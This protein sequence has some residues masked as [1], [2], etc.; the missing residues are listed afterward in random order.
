VAWKL[1]PETVVRAGWGLFYDVAF[2]IATDPIN[3]LPYNR[4]QFSSSAGFGA[5]PVVIPPTVASY[6]PGL[7]LPYAGEWN[8]SIEHL[9]PRAGTLAASYVGS[10]GVAGLRREG[11]SNAG[12]RLVN[13]LVSTN[14]GFSHFHALEM[15]YH[16]ALAS[17]LSAT[18]AYTY[19]HSIDNGSWDN[20]VYYTQEPWTAASDRAS[21]SY[22]VRHNFTASLVWQKKNWRVAAIARARSGFPID[23]L[24]AENLLGLSFDDATR[25]DLVAGVPRWLADPHVLGGHRLNPAAFSTPV[26]TLQGN[27]GRNAIAGFGFYQLD[28][29]V[30]RGFALAGR[31]RLDLRADAY[32]ALNH[33]MPGDP[34]PYLDSPLFGVANAGLNAVLGAGSPHSGLA[35]SLQMGS[36]R[37]LQFTVRFSF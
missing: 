37:N 17:G 33:A 6:A 15:Q 21:S 2:S 18:A 12:S 27:L 19:A 8:L 11:A 20:A 30:S 4:W 14:D 36:P 35:P 26:G 3:G 34:I 16:R 9:F 10:H 31:W 25:P 13:S 5:A 22:D 1:A 32:N 24:A 23:V 28:L 29:G 7:R